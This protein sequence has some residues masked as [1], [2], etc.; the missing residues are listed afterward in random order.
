MYPENKPLH[1]TTYKAMQLPG[2]QRGLGLPVALFIIVVMALIAVAV[3]NLNKNSSQNFVQ[4]LLST[5]AFYAAESGAQLRLND[6]IL[7][8]PCSCGAN[9]DV[10]YVF[11][12]EIVGLSGC[13]AA[14]NCIA[15]TAAGDTYCTVTSSGFCNGSNASRQ[16]EVRVK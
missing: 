8:S 6:V 16:I 15:F 2:R 3:N 12:D 1:K 9:A 7:A 4:N 5:R 14:T 13:Q 11:A 10:S